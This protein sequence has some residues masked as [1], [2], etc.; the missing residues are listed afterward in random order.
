MGLGRAPIKHGVEPQYLA[1]RP[2]PTLP[3][4]RVAGHGEQ[5]AARAGHQTVGDA[6]VQ[7]H[8][9]V[10]Q[11]VKPDEARQRQ[12]IAA[13]HYLLEAAQA[14]KNE[15]RASAR[16]DSHPPLDRCGELHGA[17]WWRVCTMVKVSKA[18]VRAGRRPATHSAQ[19]R[20][21]SARA[22]VLGSVRDM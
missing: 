19:A 8:L 4:P 21:M 9:A 10:Q 5:Q 22:S 15:Q 12:H 18:T 13:L 3:E 11:H 17:Y 20:L 2:Q 7:L 14:V 1:L 6:L 16:C